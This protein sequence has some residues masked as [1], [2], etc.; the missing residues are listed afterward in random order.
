MYVIASETHPRKTRAFKNFPHSYGSFNIT[1]L[2]MHIYKS[3]W[4]FQLF[5]KVTHHYVLKGVL[6][7]SINKYEADLVRL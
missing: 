4:D 7:K 2:A 1:S 3:K 5:K 6:Q